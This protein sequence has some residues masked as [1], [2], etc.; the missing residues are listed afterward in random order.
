MPGELEAATGLRRVVH[1]AAGMLAVQLDISV[2]DA[3]LTI[4]AH[5]FST[6]TPID[7]VGRAIVN[8][9]L[10][11]GDESGSG[12]GIDDQGRPPV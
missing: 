3:L 12:E 1:Q 2:A 7:R 4:R 11:L 10:R 9:E 8:R 6:A 5:A